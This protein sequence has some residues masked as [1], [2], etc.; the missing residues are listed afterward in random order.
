MDKTRKLKNKLIIESSSSSSSSNKLKSSKPNINEVEPVLD[1]RFVNI[2]LNNETTFDG[3][4]TLSSLGN[5]LK[6]QIPFNKHKHFN[7]LNQIGKIKPVDWTGK[8][9]K[10]ETKQKMRKSKNVG[11]NNP[12]YGTCWVKNET[13]SKRIKKDELSKYLISLI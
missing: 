5:K 8:K 1:S 12:Q 13:E 3:W 4:I 10:E 7:K 9:H 11:E 6:I 2:D